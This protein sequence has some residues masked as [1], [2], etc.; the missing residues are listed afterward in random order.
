MTPFEENNLKY[1]IASKGKRFGN[2]IVDYIFIILIINRNCF[3]S[4][5]FN[6]F[7]NNKQL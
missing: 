5:I 7:R 3:N 6:N 4:W 1:K 2:Y